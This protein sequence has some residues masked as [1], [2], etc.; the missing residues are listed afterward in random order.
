MTWILSKA[1]MEAYANSHSSQEPGADY[2]EASCSDG[3]QYAPLNVMPTPHP[4]WLRDKTTD[5]LSHSLFGQMSAL[6]TE[7]LGEDALMWFREDFLAKTSPQQEKEQESREADQDCG[8]KWRGLSVKYDPD[9]HS[10]KT[11]HCLFQEDLPWSSVIL[12]NWG[13]FAD[14]EL[15]ELTTL[16]DFTA[17]NGAGSGQSWPTPRAGN[18]G[19]RKPGT[20]GKV[21][22]EEVKK[23][24]T[25]A[26][27]DWK[28]SPGMSMTGTNP[29]GTERTRVDQLARAVYHGRGGDRQAY[30]TPTASDYKGRGPNSQQ[31]G[32]PEIVKGMRSFPT[33]KTNGFC[34]GSGAAQMVNNLADNGQIDED[35]RRSMRAGNGGQL[36]PDWVE[37]LM[38]WP[39]S[40]TRLNPLPVMDW[41]TWDIDPADLPPDHPDYIPRVANGIDNRIDRL[42]AIGNGQVPLTAATA[43]QTLG[44]L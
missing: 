3:E 27:R 33:P 24:P 18:P 19:S 25:P 38:G 30:P 9:T 42:R 11:H 40:W 20:G 29:D 6:L 16:P 31:Q 44:E 8:E 5:I 10:W 14:G 4:F 32:L 1:L 17:E 34:S 35:T 13:M 28:D 12:P 21:L 36:N 43:W 39:C 41:L 7:R 37:W 26:S 22:S 23:W 2:S 15:W